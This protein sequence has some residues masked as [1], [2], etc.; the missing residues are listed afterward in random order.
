MRTLVALSLLLV[1]DSLRAGCDPSHSMTSDW[2]LSTLAGHAPGKPSYW[3]N[4]VG[5]QAEWRPGFSGPVQSR[6][7]FYKIVY[8]S[9]N[10]PDTRLE[11]TH[12]DGMAAV[13]VNANLGESGWVDL[14]LYSFAG[15]CEERVLLTKRT[16]GVNTRLSALRFDVYSEASN[17]VIGSFIL[18]Q[19]TSNTPGLLPVRWTDLADSHFRSPVERLSF[20]G[21]VEGAS[22][23]EFG[24]ELPILQGDYAMWLLRAAGRM[25]V[26]EGAAARAQSTPALRW[27][28]AEAGRALGFLD[29][30][31]PERTL[32]RADLAEMTAR[33]IPR[34]GVNLDW[35]PRQPAE[36]AHLAPIEYVRELGLLDRE[37]E[38]GGS[39]TR[40]QAALLFRRFVDAFID[41]GPPRNRRW[42]LTFQDEFDGDALN[43]GRWAVESGS[44]GHILSSRWPENVEVGDGVLRLHTRKEQRGG[45]E[46]TTGHI[47]STFRQAYGYYEARMKIGAASG[48]NNAFWLI[49][50]QPKFEIDIT[51]S[52][53]PRRHTFTI[54][55]QRR[56]PSV[57]TGKQWISNFDLSEDFHVFGAAWDEEGVTFYLDGKEVGRTACDFCA[58]AAPIRFSSAIG[59]WAGPITDALDG[60]RMEVE[61]VR[62]YQLVK[63]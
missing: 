57:A 42:R 24:G 28:A 29:I 10:D 44:P 54:H 5:A 14:G 2:A 41:G 34:L 50:P 23:Q 36:A 62:V 16:T 49:S 38:E 63:Q 1:P 7:W 4:R 55:D 26:K 37:F 6:V 22:A 58:D 12:A 52:H 33:M 48:L 8:T 15:S 32:G 53:Y 11:I 51:E 40:L 39:V 13:S 18:D 60:T 25:P 61:W 43:R 45:K 35:L 20:R 47:W 27:E 56:S 30:A 19:I 21:F 17:Q 59:A 9:G 46:W 3:T 31:E